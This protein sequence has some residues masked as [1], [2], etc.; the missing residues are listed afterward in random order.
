[1]IFDVHLK[2]LTQYLITLQHMNYPY[3]KQ[4]KH[5]ISF[6]VQTIHE[7]YIK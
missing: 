4:G 5:Y 7:Q 3:K 6:K 2:Y 1:M